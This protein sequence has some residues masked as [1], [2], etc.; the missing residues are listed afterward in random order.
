[1]TIFIKF[2]HFSTSVTDCLG[3][4]CSKNQSHR[5][6]P[7]VEFFTDPLA[8]S[9]LETFH[10]RLQYFEYFQPGATPSPNQTPNV[11]QRYTATNNIEFPT[12]ISEHRSVTNVNSTERSANK[13]KTLNR[14]TD[15]KKK[16]HFI[17]PATIPYNCNANFFF[18]FSI[19]LREK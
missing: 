1:M 14:P 12:P 16:T 15:E 17:V 9:I 19:S 4:L 6:Q 8:G 13:W 11:Y 10:R 5:F 18:L 3:G 7:P 2:P